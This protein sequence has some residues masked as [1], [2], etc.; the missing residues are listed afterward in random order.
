MGHV[1]K[2]WAY[3]NP[4]PRDLDTCDCVIRAL[5]AVTGKDWYEV[6]DKC[7]EIARENATMPNSNKLAIKRCEAF[8]LEPRTIARPKKGEKSLTVRAFCKQH[9]HGKFIL[10]TVH[11]DLAVIDG[12]YYDTYKNYGQKVYKYY[13]KVEKQ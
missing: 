6:F 12:K 13:E 8:G 5:C 1:D 9:P 10:S 7:C 11:H 4:N 2:L 3:Y